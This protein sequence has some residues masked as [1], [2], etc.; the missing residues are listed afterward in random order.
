MNRRRAWMAGGVL[1]VGVLPF[2]LGALLIF[3]LSSTPDTTGGACG[4]PGQGVTAIPVAAFPTGA[5]GL[6]AAQLANAAIIVAV[7]RSMGLPANGQV[8]AVAVARQESALMN[9]N[10]GDRDSL[11]LF[12]QRPSQGWGTPAQIM[13]PHYSAH[14][15]YAALQLVPRWQSMPVTVA[16]QTVQRSAY[17]DAYA[18]WEPMARAVVGA[19]PGGPTTP[20]PGA[21]HVGCTPPP[22]GSSTT[23]G[24][25]ATGDFT[26]PMALPVPSSGWTQDQGV[27]MA[28][29]GGA[30]GAAA[31]E[32]AV[33]H[34]T[35]TR[36]G[37]DGFGPDAPVLLIDQGPLAGRAVYYGHAAPALVPVGAVVNAGQAI[38]DVGCGIVGMSSGPHIEIGIS[39]P[40]S[41]G[42]PSFQ[43]TSA[44]MMSLLLGSVQHA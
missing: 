19:G 27:D 2:L 21:V 32:Y 6:N 4:T 28:T 22:H 15:F 39:P 11:G 16:A 40:G 7:G 5:G 25:I 36:E 43:Q 12:Q 13:D 10:Y 18:P 44:E 38:A 17:P 8:I 3:S 34:G 31:P 26:F 35:I 1:A 23:A 37:I 9:L 24:A 20:T 42:F 14:A 30:C 41:A 33:A 29:V